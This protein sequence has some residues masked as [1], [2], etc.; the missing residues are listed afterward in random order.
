M[1][2]SAAWVTIYYEFLNIL[3]ITL[4]KQRP[5]LSIPTKWVYFKYINQFETIVGCTRD[6]IKNYIKL[7]VR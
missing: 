3:L 2:F 7:A 6:E 1:I 4:Q 5:Y